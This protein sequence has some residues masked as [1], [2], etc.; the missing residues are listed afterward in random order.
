MNA[1]FILCAAS[2]EEECAVNQR[3]GGYV[4]TK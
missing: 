4:H 1:E 3:N 2:F